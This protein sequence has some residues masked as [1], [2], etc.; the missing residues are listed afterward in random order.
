VYYKQSLDRIHRRVNISSNASWL[1]KVRAQPAT[2][3][4]L[5]VPNSVDWLVRDALNRK[6]NVAEAIMTSDEVLTKIGRE[7]LLRYL[8]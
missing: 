1:D 2:L 4:F 5:D 3:I 7:D 6:D 8:R